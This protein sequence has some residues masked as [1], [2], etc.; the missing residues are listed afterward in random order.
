MAY[1][2]R[3]TPDTAT[4]PRK[5]L[6]FF[7]LIA[8]DDLQ[9]SSLSPQARSFCTLKASLWSWS[10]SEVIET[11]Q[12]SYF[13]GSLCADSQVYRQGFNLVYHIYHG[14]G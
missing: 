8:S 13:F 4:F 11:S 14:C 1:L 9:S 6:V 7:D 12:L 10:G 2:S 5:A 3:A